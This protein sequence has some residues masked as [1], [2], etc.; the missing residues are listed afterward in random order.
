MLPERISLALVLRKYAEKL[1]GQGT[2]PRS[3]DIQSGLPAD[4]RCRYSLT[5]PLYI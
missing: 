3:G 5:L 4:T 2:A 1:R